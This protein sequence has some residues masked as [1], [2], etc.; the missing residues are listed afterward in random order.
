MQQPIPKSR[1]ITS[2]LVVLATIYLC[3]KSMPF[4]IGISLLLGVIE[5][6]SRLRSDPI[7]KSLLEKRK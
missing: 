1:R 3:A 6:V 5:M 4:V 2:V 7:P